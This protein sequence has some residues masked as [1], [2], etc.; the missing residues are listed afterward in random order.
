M[1]EIN[2]SKES[3]PLHTP[4]S[5]ADTAGTAIFLEGESFEGGS[6]KNGLGGI[7]EEDEEYTHR[8]SY[9]KQKSET[10]NSDKFA[11]DFDN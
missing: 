3:K 1:G 5:T 6:E 4:S 9:R 10:A 8:Q 2:D 7:S 11:E